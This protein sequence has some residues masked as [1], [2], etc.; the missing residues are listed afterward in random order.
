MPEGAEGLRIGLAAD[1]GKI[2]YEMGTLVADG[3][4]VTVHGRYTGWAPTP[5]TPAGPDHRPRSGSAGQNITVGRPNGRPTV[6]FCHP[7]DARETAAP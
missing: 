3:D 5:L 7:G 2:G 6:M 1:G 4:F